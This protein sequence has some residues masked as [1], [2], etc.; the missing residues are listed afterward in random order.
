MN[1]A[2]LGSLRKVGSRAALVA[3]ALVSIAFAF[4]LVFSCPLPFVASLWHSSLDGTTFN[5]RYRVADGL[6]LTGRL[7][8]KTKA[9]VLELLG[10]P[11]PTDKFEDHDLVYV[12]GPERSW[13]S[14]DYEWLLVDFDSTGRASSV[15]VVS[16]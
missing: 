11:P 5:T 6:E 2:L 8:G 7:N 16:D 12:L 14:L 9:E 3:G 15:T 10:P 13:I 1:E 4:W